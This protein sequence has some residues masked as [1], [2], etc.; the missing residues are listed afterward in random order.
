MPVAAAAY[1]ARIRESNAR[2]TWLYLEKQLRTSDSQ[3]QRI[4]G[5]KQDTKGS[6]WFQ[7]AEAIGAS[8]AKLATLL[9]DTSK[10]KE[11]GIRAA[12]WWLALNPEQ[13]KMYE[14]MLA[15]DQG[16]GYLLRAA[17]DVIDSLQ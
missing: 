10:P 1:L 13:Q 11:D 2:Y 7:I 15:H 9:A 12:E 5:G 3:L 16:R 14:S 6:T 4:L 17:A 8:K